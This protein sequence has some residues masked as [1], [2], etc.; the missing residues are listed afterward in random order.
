MTQQPAATVTATATAAPVYTVTPT[1]P[2][3]TVAPTATPYS[4]RTVQ[5]SYITADGPFA[6]TTVTVSP[7]NNVIT[8]DASMVPSG[9]SPVVTGPVTIAFDN[10]GAPNPAT[11]V[12]LYQAPARVNAR[13]VMARWSVPG[14]RV[15]FGSYEQDNNTANGKEPVEW[16]VLDT[17]QA[18]QALLMSRYALDMQRFNSEWIKISWQDCSL[19]TW[20][21]GT[22]YQSCFNL[23]QQKAILSSSVV[24]RYVDRDVQTYDK[25]FCLSA[26]EAKRYL[27]KNLLLC[28]PT[29]YASARP[30]AKKNGYCYWWLRDTTN[31][32]N[33]ANRVDYEGI[34][35]EYGANTN[36]SGVGVRPVIWVDVDKMLNP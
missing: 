9:Y 28:T 16:I 11:V 23:H 35:E 32:K 31:R 29:S 30:V 34:I 1:V 17:N 6:Q 26:A 14:E 21:N 19:R 10:N 4:A 33:D 24:S 5:V 18:G 25:V 27:S 15:I 2:V 36:A 22:F 3:R 20:L 8:P 7:A 13:S 12:F